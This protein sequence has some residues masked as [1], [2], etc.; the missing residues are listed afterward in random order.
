[1]HKVGHASEAPWPP[2]V[3]EAVLCL[4]AGVLGRVWV[5]CELLVVS[6]LPQGPGPVGSLPTCP[7]FFG[8]CA[9][10]TGVDC[11]NGGRG[12]FLL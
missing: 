3:L 12:H 10:T 7:G 9:D 8:A 1:M 11:K 4:P 2:A 5:G 6:T